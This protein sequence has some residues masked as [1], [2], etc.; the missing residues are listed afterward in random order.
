MVTVVRKRAARALGFAAC[1]ALAACSSHG[2]APTSSGPKI[3][4]ITP[5]SVSPGKIQAPPMAKPAIVPMDT[6]V[7]PNDAIGSTFW[8]PIPGTGSFAAAGT[9]GSLWVLSD[10]P[11]GSDKF[12]YHY[13]NGVWTQAAGTATRLTVGPDN[14]L[15]AINSGGGAYQYNSGTNTFTPLGGGC[16]DIT[17]ASDGSVYVLSNGNAPGSDQAIWHYI[18]GGW[19]QAAGSGVRIAG[20]WDPQT[21]TLNNGG[22][23]IAA[24]GLYIVNSSG[25]IYYENTSQA[26][27]L[28]PGQASS[29]AP[30]SSSGLYVLGA[31]AGSGG[32]P[33]F[34][35]DLD[36]QSYGSALGSATNISTDSIKLYA[37]GTAGGLYYTNRN[38]QDTLPLRVVNNSG[39]TP[40]YVTILGLN[41]TDDTDAA[42]Y[43]VTA[44][45]QAVKFATGDF[46]P[47]NGGAQG[48]TTSYSIAIP[49]GGLAMQLPYLKSARIYISL[50]AP[51][52]IVANLPDLTWAS[53]AL[54][55]NATDPDFNLLT[56][57]I[58]FNY[59]I[60][61]KSHVSQL[62][63]NLTQVDL[64]SIPMQQTVTGA[65]H[66]T[67]TT[68]ILPNSRAAI[69]NALSADPTFSVLVINKTAT[70]TSVSPLR[71]ISVKNAIKNTDNNTAN[72]PHW[73]NMS[74][75]D[76]Y[77]SSVWTF[78]KSHTL[79]LYTSAFG[80]YTGTVNGSNQ[81]VFSQAGK[82]DVV[83]P[84]PSTEDALTGTGQMVSLPCGGF[85]GDLFVACK[86]LVSMLSAG[87]NRSS[88]TLDS[89]V[90]RDPSHHPCN[91]TN[92]YKT[93]PINLYSQIMH[94]YSVPTV[95]APGGA[96]YGFDYDDV[97]EQSSTLA[98]DSPTA[99]T[100]TI[101]PF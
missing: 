10:Q 74:Y 47:I 30:T 16:S 25:A 93:P 6:N 49:S 46:T 42:R 26:F 32:Y 73:A 64:F 54:T 79:T 75:F 88:L 65:I 91:L 100:I 24:G 97:C 9:D 19:T 8:Q 14:T 36:A 72:V 68:G 12:I 69:M 41:G 17:V 22:G 99:W 66:G 39:I 63:A 70:G 71:A 13:V 55:S 23:T 67:Q 51:L 18:N 87:I 40:A 86:E 50:G 92:F 35:F 20:N 60:N 80:T 89:F 38:S 48:S 83:F 56:D 98:D 7:K 11:A 33:I 101:E 76:N 53:P 84:V 28:L 5:T 94:K 2:I 57:F 95:Q 43:H 21:Y 31:T 62:F 85:S 81:F 59:Q 52:T 15:Y 90:S 82:P 58:E 44:S 61:A 77:I 1:I 78:Y 3:I 34:Y 27:A 45:G 4:P 37:V 29:V 96:A